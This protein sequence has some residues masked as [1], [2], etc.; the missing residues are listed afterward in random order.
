[1]FEEII[2]YVLSS[3]KIFS[4]QLLILF[5]PFMVLALAINTM[6]SQI[7]KVFGYSNFMRIFYLFQGPGIVLHELAHGFFVVIFGYQI[8]KF[9]PFVL[10]PQKNGGLA[11]CVE[12][13]MTQ[14]DM[15]SPIYNFS[16][17]VIGIAPILFGSF[18]IIV[19]TFLFFPRE[20]N[21]S[22]SV[23][24]QPLEICSLEHFFGYFKMV[25]INAWQMFRAIFFTVNFLNPLTWLYIILV[26][27]A[28]SSITLSRLDCSP[29]AI[30]GFVELIIGLALVNLFLCWWGGNWIHYSLY[31]T[32]YNHIVY[33]LLLIV[34]F[35]QCFI[36][37][38]C[39]IIT[40]ATARK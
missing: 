29:G 11:G 17:F 34:I 40:I 16:L 23:V 26:Y 3:L 25:F 12:Y 14:E 35:I 10:N 1:M 38:I 19:L 20:V 5:V 8:V 28:G 27:S 24:P 37:A 32:K 9:V 22:L 4:I 2:S 39:T 21:S 36:L 31:I 15:Q 6:S 33:S 30:K 7:E 18:V 13:C